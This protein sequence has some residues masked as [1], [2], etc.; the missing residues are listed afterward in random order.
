MFCST[1]DPVE[2]PSDDPL[3]SFSTPSF[4][5]PID[6]DIFDYEFEPN[7]TI[8]ITQ[9]QQES[10]KIDKNSGLKTMGPGQ[11]VKQ[12]STSP[13]Q[14]ATEVTQNPQLAAQNISCF[15]D[16]SCRFPLLNEKVA[17]TDNE[18]A[19][20]SNLAAKHVL[21]LSADSDSDE[22]QLEI[23]VEGPLVEFENS[24]AVC[25]NSTQKY[26]Q[27]TPE[28]LKSP[29]EQ[30]SLN[31]ETFDEETSAQICLADDFDNLFDYGTSS[32]NYYIAQTFLSVLH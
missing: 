18:T 6:A 16:S 8:S 25:E 13:A 30:F 10:S 27:T 21:N 24:T 2:E 17:K 14:S 15:T 20:N 22:G 4:Q 5:N 31:H 3:F 11:D 23:V 7:S 19:Q 9:N 12:R 32:G 1:Q 26:S 29:T 28:P